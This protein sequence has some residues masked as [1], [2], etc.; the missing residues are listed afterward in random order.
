MIVG[1]HSKR[2][3]SSV[4]SRT[5]EGKGR[6]TVAIAT[7]GA[8]AATAGEATLNSLITGVT[9]GK[10]MLSGLGSSMKTL[11]MMAILNEVGQLVAT[12]PKP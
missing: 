7:K 1:D 10:I 9:F 5:G 3:R 6:T 8:I 12:C 4:N 11:S 2:S